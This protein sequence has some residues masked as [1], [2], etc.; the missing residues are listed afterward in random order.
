ME[1]EIEAKFLDVDLTELRAKLEKIGATLEH[2]ERPMR[3]KTYD[4][5]LASLRKIGGWVR[6]RDEGDKTTLSYK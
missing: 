6:L 5:K 1:T 3:R 2:P 4:D